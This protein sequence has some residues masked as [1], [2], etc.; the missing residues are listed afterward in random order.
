[1]SKANEITVNATVE[2]EHMQEA[3]KVLDAAHAYWTWRQKNGFH[4][5]VTWIRDDAG[6]LLVFTRGEYDT[7]IEKAIREQT[8]FVDA[9][10]VWGSKEE[11]SAND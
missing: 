11:E 7:V 1:M 4:G 10:T 5:A 8:G 9:G 6:R 2:D 3:Q